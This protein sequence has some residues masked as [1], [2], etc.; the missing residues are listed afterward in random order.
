MEI[1]PKN[2][3]DGDREGWSRKKKLL[4]M[5]VRPSGYIVS[6]VFGPQQNAETKVG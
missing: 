2:T 5:I 3:Q 1:V 4:E 6:L